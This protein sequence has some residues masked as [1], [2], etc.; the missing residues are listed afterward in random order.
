[1]ATMG[2]QAGPPDYNTTWLK[3]AMIDGISCHQETLNHVK[4]ILSLIGYD[5]VTHESRELLV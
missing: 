1:M 3:L 2:S 4:C 5:I